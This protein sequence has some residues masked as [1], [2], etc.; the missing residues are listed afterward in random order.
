MI[1]LGMPCLACEKHYNGIYD[2]SDGATMFYWS[3]ATEDMLHSYAAQLEELGYVKHQE[4]ATLCVKSATYRKDTLSVHLYYL[5]KTAE[6]RVIMQENA[7]LPIN[8]YAYE[9]VCDVAVTQLG[10]YQDPKVYTGM[11]Y[12][13]RLEDGTFVVIDGG[14]GFDYNA[15]LLYNL[16][17][18][19][20]PEGMENIIV[21]AWIITHAHGDHNGVY[22]NFTRNYTDKVTVKLLIGNDAP[23]LVFQ[24]ADG[25]CLHRFDY[26]AAGELFNCAYMKAHTGQQFLFPGVALT[27]LYTHEDLYPDV[28]TSYNDTSLVCDITVKGE[29]V[30]AP[31]NKGETRFLFLADVHP[32]GAQQLIDMYGEQLKCDVMQIAHHGIS[33][34]HTDLYMLCNP[35]AAYW[36]CGREVLE[37]KNGSR[38]ERP[39]I[40]YLVDTTEQMIFQAK[41]THTF[42][43]EGKVARQSEIPTDC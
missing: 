38:F 28:V 5:E 3:D 42:W 11:G 14:S 21:S 27:V 16:M 13:I 8:T 20:K 17:L 30:K 9:K 22:M 19:Q 39:H 26:K 41:G 29:A 32:N 43:F 15:E 12:L 23:D 24:S 31:L 7:I 37:Y 18:D 4:L 6:L 25:G 35:M 2:C 34:Y 33:C 10:L 36:P 1:Y 40:K